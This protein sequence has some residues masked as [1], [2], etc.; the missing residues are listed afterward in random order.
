VAAS[1]LC[2]RQ[3]YE[4]PAIGQAVEPQDT[5]V[6]GDPDAGHQRDG[7]RLTP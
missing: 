4:P 5:L 1:L 7:Q 6:A 3:V 2:S